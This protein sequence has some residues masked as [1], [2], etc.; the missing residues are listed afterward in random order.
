M[1]TSARDSAKAADKPFW[2]S[3]E[4]GT[5]VRYDREPLAGIWRRFLAKLLGAFAPE[6]LL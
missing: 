3:E 5:E 4:A 6:E 1:R 2:M